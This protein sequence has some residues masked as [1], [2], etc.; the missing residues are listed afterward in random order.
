MEMRN[1]AV[2]EGEPD[3]S[4][5]LRAGIE[6]HL[7]HSIG[8]NPS[9][10]RLTDW[11][12]A[13]SL[14]VRDRIME[15]W[16]RTA[17]RI[18][19]E[20]R[21]RV[22]YLSMEFLT[23]RFLEDA[24]AN[25]G[26]WDA[27]QEAASA[28]GLEYDE[29]LADEPDAALGNGG[30]GRL[31]ACFLESMSSIGVAGTGYGIRFAHGLFRQGFDD[32]WQAEEAEDWLAQRNVWEFERGDAAFEVG[33][34]G[35]VERT[36][37]GAAWRPDETVRAV[38]F[39]MPI[40]GWGCRWVNTLRL[41]SA[42]PVRALDLDVF[43]R[44]DFIGARARAIHAETVCRV[45]YPD[46]TTPHGRELRLRQ[47]YFF[48]SASL[49]DI[50]RRLEV[51][52]DD[53]AA[54]PG[55]VAIQL[56]DTHPAIAGPEL[57]RLLMDER[58]L[59]FDAAFDIARNTLHYTNH[60]LM[61]EA[62][63][64]W[65]IELMDRILPRHSEL[66]GMIDERHCRDLAAAG[67]RCRSTA[68]I[69]NGG[70]V[71]MGELAFV[72][73]RRVNGVS[74]LHTELMKR[75]VFSDLHDLHPDRILNQTNGVTPR[76]W[77][78]GC[79][80]ELRNLLT[81]AIGDGW[82][83]NLE[84]LSEIAPLA[85][86]SSFRRRF[87]AAKRANKARLANWSGVVGGQAIDP[88]AMFDVQIKR[89]H[90]YKRQFLN[91]LETVAL[92]NEMRRNPGFVEV[93]RVKIF[94]GKAAPGY[95]MAKLV[96]KLIND[97]ARVINSDPRTQGRITILFPPNYNV[98]MAERFIPAADLSEQISTAGKEASGTGNMKFALNGALT[99]GTPDGATVEIAERVGKDN[100]FI[101]G[102]SADEVAE[103]RRGYRPEN[104][105]SASPRL[106][107]VLE[108]ISGGTFSPD[109]PARFHPLTDSLRRDDPYMLCADFDAYWDAQREVD[110]AW[111]DRSR[112]ERSAVLNTALSGWF[113]SDR[114]VRGYAAEIWQVEA[115]L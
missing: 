72:M 35:T 110:S 39:D 87:T 41:W 13:L 109:D 77:L 68:G 94:G 83:G 102:M 26:L 65:P 29:L 47:E 79:N 70:E 98:S 105:I 43:N 86:D 32:G 106:A 85:E 1:M 38:A 20:G 88:D 57:V 99:I 18:S 89:F 49:R 31:A 40:I 82:V 58:G 90:E 75:S 50:I 53:A 93:P 60:T 113:S 66:I 112:W 36:G 100:I 7:T 21:K 61:P 54:L 91:L 4:R 2:R 46:D 84:Q 10:A 37:K 108:Q 44:G 5:V 59:E 6:R 33:F 81:E 8:R 14:A 9:G 69:R 73:A 103:R 80:R 62:L 97:V 56:N 23:G 25:L 48:T 45:L 42:K 11:R 104:A 3:G 71:R 67:R 19:A 64:C 12:L 111:L 30:L 55:K 76:R 28:L 114:A 101:F 96:I 52:G 51:G 16:L 95:L 27:A 78:H 24:I 92:W 15:P 63:E 22:C 115:I 107:E 34:G 74:A 17:E